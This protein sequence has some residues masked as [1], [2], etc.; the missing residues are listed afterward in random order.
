MLHQ[1]LG[2]INHWAPDWGCNK[3]YWPPKRGACGS[4]NK[5]GLAVAKNK[6][7][8]QT[9]GR[10]LVKYHNGTR[11]AGRLMGKCW[12]HPCLLPL[13][14]VSWALLLLHHSLGSNNDHWLCYYGSDIHSAVVC[15]VFNRHGS[16]GNPFNGIQIDALFVHIPKRGKMAQ[17][18]HSAD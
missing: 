5:W 8:M 14:R 15:S 1:L 6:R 7:P 3:P 13:Y 18:V 9:L 4:A 12:L 16:M 17:M 11:L 10:I 2:P